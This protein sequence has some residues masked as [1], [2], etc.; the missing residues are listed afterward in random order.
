MIKK[1][2][3]KDLRMCKNCTGITSIFCYYCG[4]GNPFFMHKS[5]ATV[6]SAKKE[7][8][9]IMSAIEMFFNFDGDEDD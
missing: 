9:R 8:E 4:K 3:D 7:S 1:K 5:H 6:E 2:T